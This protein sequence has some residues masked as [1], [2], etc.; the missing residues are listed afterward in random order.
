MDLKKEITA[1]LQDRGADLVGFTSPDRWVKDGRVSAPYRPDALW[2]L[3]RSIIVI[4][5]QMPLPVVETTPSVQHRDLYNTCNR[6]LDDLAFA[7]RW[8]IF[9]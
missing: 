9:A 5:I 1:Y 4:G 2:P 8:H 7:I 3:T 6:V